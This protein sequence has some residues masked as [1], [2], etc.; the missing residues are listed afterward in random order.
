MQSATTLK[1]D[2]LRL[3]IADLNEVIFKV[4]RLI[5]AGKAAPN[6]SARYL[7]YL[8]RSTEL[9]AELEVLGVSEVFASELFP[10]PHRDQLVGLTAEQRKALE[11]KGVFV[12]YPFPP[13]I[14]F[15]FSI[16]AE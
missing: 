16:A 10:I 1:I 7:S 9:R 3:T 6:A 8:R 12:S 13:S 2:A 14:P 11:W 5:D 4:R 15:H